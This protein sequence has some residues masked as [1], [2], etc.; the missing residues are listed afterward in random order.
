MPQRCQDLPNRQIFIRIKE[1]TSL[2][3]ARRDTDAPRQGS[4]GGSWRMTDRQPKPP[5][6]HENHPFLADSNASRR[7]GWHVG[8]LGAT[9]E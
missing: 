2:R 7:Y 9:P 6:G 3:R 4:G 8:A 1:M 5:H